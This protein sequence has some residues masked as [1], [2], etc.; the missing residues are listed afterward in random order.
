MGITVTMATS[1]GRERNWYS[2][3]TKMRPGHSEREKVQRTCRKGKQVKT[4]TSPM[5]TINTNMKAGR[6]VDLVVGS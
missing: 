3:K 6:L 5:Y 2:S 4:K 1:Q